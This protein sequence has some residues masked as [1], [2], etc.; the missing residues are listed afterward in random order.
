MRLVTGSVLRDVSAGRILTVS[1][2][3]I[4]I[5]LILLKTG[6]S[7]YMDIAGLVLLGGGLAGGFPIMLGFVGSRY[8][9]LSGTAFSFVLFVGLLGNMLINY[10]MGIISQNL[11]IKHLITVAF[12]ESVIM[13]FLCLIILKRLK[14][15]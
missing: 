11:G 1:F 13:I 5:S 7:Y 3:M 6:S 15:Q 12:G 8:A 2:T 14:K 4:L 9:E 10:L